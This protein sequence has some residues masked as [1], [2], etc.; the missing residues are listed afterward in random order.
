MYFTRSFGDYWAAAAMPR[1]I[2]FH[3]STIRVSGLSDASWCLPATSSG[4]TLALPASMIRKP[5]PFPPLEIALLMIFTAWSCCL[6]YLFR[7]Q[8]FQPQIWLHPGGSGR[9][10]KRTAFCTSMSC[11]SMY[12][13]PPTG[14]AHKRFMIIIFHSMCEWDFP[15]ISKCMPRAFVSCPVSI[16]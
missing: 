2:L 16:E 7:G 6:M 9:L 5:P 13:Y 14:F 1:I 12:V 8:H 11:T 3:S 15:G 4:C 10:G